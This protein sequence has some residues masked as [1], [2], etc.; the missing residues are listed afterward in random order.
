MAVNMQQQQENNPPENKCAT[1]SQ[2]FP[3]IQMPRLRSCLNS[4]LRLAAQ[5]HLSVY[6][7]WVVGN[8]SALLRYIGF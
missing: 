4:V 5:I 1:A 2:E 8:N 6:F 7:L 3:L